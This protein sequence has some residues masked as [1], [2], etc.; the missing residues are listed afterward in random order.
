[1]GVGCE[2]RDAPSK[3]IT[4]AETMTA[5]PQNAKR[6]ANSPGP[7]LGVDAGPSGGSA[8]AFEAAVLVHLNA[9]YTLARYLTRRSDIAEDIVQEALL[10]AYRSFGSQ[11]GGNSRA[12]LLAIVRNCFLTWNARNRENPEP[13]ESLDEQEPAAEWDGGRP[14]QETP[15]SILIQHQESSVVR[16]VIEGL[17]QL[18]RE[19]LVL[20]DIEELSYREIADIAG[21]P[22][23]TVMSRLA[24]ARKLFAAA[25]MGVAIPAVKDLEP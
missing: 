9:A 5:R 17:P 12:W 4:P 22:I 18:F 21:V 16:S 24:R 3:R 20:R 14:E 7:A 19:V 10:R 25:W 15:E 23:G 13:C 6:R 11:R 1:M 2:N 8:V